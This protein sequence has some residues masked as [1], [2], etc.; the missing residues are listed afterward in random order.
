MCSVWTKCSASGSNG[1]TSQFG[2]GDSE[3][4]VILAQLE[5]GFDAIILTSQWL[6]ILEADVMWRWDLS[7]NLALAS[8]HDDF[9]GPRYT[10]T[11]LEIGNVGLPILE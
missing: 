6:R 9:L 1:G 7:L 11:A 4:P 8:R 3:Q 10:L 2:F 5:I